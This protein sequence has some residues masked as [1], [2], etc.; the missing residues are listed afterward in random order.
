MVIKPEK[1]RFLTSLVLRL[2]LTRKCGFNSAYRVVVRRYGLSEQEAEQYYKL[3]YNII[4]YYHTLKFIAGY[5]GFKPNI[6]G[7]AEYLYKKSFT[8][9]LIEEDVEDAAKAF[10]KYT[11]IGL[12]YGYPQWFVKD[13]SR[14]V[15]LA[16]LESIL[17]ALNYKKRWLRVNTL[18]YSVED[19]VLCLKNTGI[20]T[21]PHEIFRDLLLQRDPFKKIGGNPCFLKGV[22]IPQDISSYII[23]QIAQNIATGEFLDACS[24][25]GL[26]LIQVLGG[27]RARRAIAVDLSGKRI[28]VLPKLLELALGQISPLIIAIQGDSRKITYSSKFHSALLDAP[29]SNSGAIYDDPAIKVHLNRKLLERAHRI[30]YSLLSALVKQSK[31]VLY[32]TCSIHP[33]EGEEVVEKLSKEHDVEIIKV[34]YPYLDSG[35]AGYTVSRSVHRVHPHRVQGQGFFVALIKS[36]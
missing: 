24:A 16:E 11:K 15:D 12:L 28:K 34:N 17:S 7:I 19:A 23:G 30:Q 32:A 9:R 33:L 14:R 18:K 8:W 27:S 20:E 21:K 35:Y 5:H 3:L 13:L 36:E 1:A 31:L 22:V 4:M 26:K 2:I 29:C 6:Q 25:P 10:S